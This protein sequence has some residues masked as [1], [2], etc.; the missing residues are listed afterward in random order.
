MTMTLESEIQKVASD[1]VPPLRAAEVH[2]EAPMLELMIVTVAEPVAGEFD[3][4]R[5][6][7]WTVSSVKASVAV[8]ACNP[9]VI[10]MN[11]V[12]LMP[13]MALHE[14]LDSDIH[15][16]ISAAVNPTRKASE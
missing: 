15:F 14:T 1:F 6:L 9:A 3:G 7:R 8:P 4:R 12:L 16:E 10:M 11:A 13:A 2:E 5:E